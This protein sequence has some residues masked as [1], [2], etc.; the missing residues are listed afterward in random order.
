MTTAFL[1]VLLVSQPIGGATEIASSVVPQLAVRKV[2]LVNTTPV[3]DADQFYRLEDGQPK[4]TGDGKYP[5]VELDLNRPVS[6][7]D[8]RKVPLACWERGDYRFVDVTW[9]NPLSYEVSGYWDCTAATFVRSSCSPP[10]TYS[11]SH[12]ISPSNSITIPATGTTTVQVMIGPLPDI[13]CIGQLDLAFEAW[14]TPIG[15]YNEYSTT[16]Y[17]TDSTPAGFMTTA[18]SEVLADSCKWADGKTGKSDCLKFCT[19]GLFNS[20]K[21]VYNGNGCYHIV[22]DDYDPKFGYFKLKEIGQTSNADC[23]DTSSYLLLATSSLGHSGSLIQAYVPGNPSGVRAI[24]T[25]PIRAIGASSYSPTGWNFHQ[26]FTDAGNVYDAC[27]ALQYEPYGSLF[28][29]V[30]TGQWSLATWWQNQVGGSYFGLTNGYYV[31]HPAAVTDR[32]FD[33]ALAKMPTLTP[34]ITI[35]QGVK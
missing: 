8:M 19:A 21:F 34:N 18:W 11:L 2:D 32:L 20:G 27:A 24:S 15:G 30:P 29:D 1:A 17:L 12:L 10:V 25:N 28:Q 4:P 33:P 6:P 9:Y 23:R 13:T 5:A 22:T 35:L 14:C 16:L 31:P 7:K 3:T 26:V